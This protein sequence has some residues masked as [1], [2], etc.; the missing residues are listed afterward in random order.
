MQ[1]DKKL[2]L[3]L[4]VLLIGIVSA[5]FFRN[6]TSFLDNFPQ[7]KNPKKLDKRIAEKPIFPY[8]TGIETEQRP[9]QQ[10]TTASPSNSAP[11]WEIP[12]FLKPGGRNDVDPVAQTPVAPNPIPVRAFTRPTQPEQAIPEH[13]KA[14]VPDS[15]NRQPRPQKKLPSTS[16][17]VTRHRVQPGE[18][19]SAL[20]DRYLGSSSRFLDLF[21]ANRDLLKSP[22]NLIVGMEIR[23]PTTES[24]TA[25]KKQ[26]AA[27]RTKTKPISAPKPALTNNAAQAVPIKTSTVK[28]AKRILWQEPP[29]ILNNAD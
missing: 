16:E 28:S 25:A 27:R 11:L 20:A 21:E 19:L 17:R 29:T 23:I 24:I 6:E 18:T 22:D 9:S 15:A 1:R 13:N 3:A 4:G 2:G 12:H 7:L 10:K 26:K 14:W 5:F 8:L